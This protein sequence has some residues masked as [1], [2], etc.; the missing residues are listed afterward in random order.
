MGIFFAKLIDSEN[1]LYYNKIIILVN[2]QKILK[3]NIRRN[4]QLYYY[5]FN[6]LIYLLQWK[7]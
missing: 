4:V 5:S 1:I 3:F 6:N 7:I 2:F